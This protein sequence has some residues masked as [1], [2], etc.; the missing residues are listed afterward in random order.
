MQPV[1]TISFPDRQLLADLTPLPEGLRGVVWD[2]KSD[3]ENA[4][5]GEIARAL[6]D[7]FGEHKE[8]VKF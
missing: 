6:R 4:T 8:P 7:V 1:R 2:M 5:L 3:P